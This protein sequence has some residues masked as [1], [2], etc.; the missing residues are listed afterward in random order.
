M[1]KYDK[2]ALRERIKAKIMAGSKGGKSGT[3]SARKSQMLVNQYEAAGGGYTGRKTATQK[4]LQRWTK[5]DWRTESGK[6]SKKTGEVYLPKRAIA[7]LK[8]TAK[9]KAANRKKRAASRKG[10]QVARTGVHKGKKR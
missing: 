3:W 9:L 2:P 7:Q 10:Q 8:G 5:Q 4:S 1:A 6:P